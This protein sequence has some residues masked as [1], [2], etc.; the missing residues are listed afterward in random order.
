MPNGF[1]PSRC[2]PASSA[3]DVELGVQVVGD[4]EVD[5]LNVRVVE[6]RAPVRG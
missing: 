1:S 2:L 6:Q 4:G 3:A 5:G